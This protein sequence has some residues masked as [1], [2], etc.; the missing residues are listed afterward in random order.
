[1]GLKMQENKTSTF[2]QIFADIVIWFIIVWAFNDVFKQ[3][4]KEC[5]ELDQAH[6]KMWGLIILG[7]F[8][9][10]CIALLT[11]SMGWWNVAP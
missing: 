2:K 4:R 1:M 9:F 3:M 10:S 8:L 6:K 5:Y 11:Y 7:L